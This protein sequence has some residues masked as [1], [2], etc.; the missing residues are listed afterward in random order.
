MVFV[1][2]SDWLYLVWEYN[3]IHVA[4]NDI[5]LFFFMAEGYSIFYCRT[6]SQEAACGF[7]DTILT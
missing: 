1:C 6:S 2:L 7:R 4:E 3:Y 5:I